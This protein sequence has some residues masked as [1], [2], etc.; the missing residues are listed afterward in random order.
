M[1]RRLTVT[2]AAFALLAAGVVLATTAVATPTPVPATDAN[3]TAKTD[4]AVTA[5][6]WNETGRKGTNKTP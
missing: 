3:V 6:D 4:A 2:L 5:A 1:T